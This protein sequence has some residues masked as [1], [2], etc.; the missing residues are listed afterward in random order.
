[1]RS[2]EQQIAGKQNLLDFYKKLLNNGQ[3][4][5]TKEKNLFLMRIKRLENGMEWLKLQLRVEKA[6]IVKQ[7]K[8]IK[9]AEK[10]MIENP[11]LFIADAGMVLKVPGLDKAEFNKFCESKGLACQRYST[12]KF[13]KWE[14]VE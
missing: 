10:W 9:L 12:M 2:K 13:Y 8:L 14:K 5:S 7:K 3:K 4:W 11:T 1:M 6:A